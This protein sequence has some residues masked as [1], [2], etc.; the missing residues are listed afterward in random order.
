MPKYEYIAP[1]QIKALAKD[2][3]NAITGKTKFCKEKLGISIQRMHQC[4]EYDRDKPNNGLDQCLAL[5]RAVGYTVHPE[6][7]AQFDKS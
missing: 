7:F 5:L 2:E 6:L 1:R 3:F 4:F